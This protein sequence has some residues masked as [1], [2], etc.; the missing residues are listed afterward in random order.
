MKVFIDMDS[1]LN[2]FLKG[3]LNYYNYYFDTDIYKT[4][5]DLYQ[6]E[7]SKCID[8][9]DEYTAEKRREIIFR[10]SNFWLDLPPFPYVKDVVGFIYQHCDV[11]ILTQPYLK[12][13][14]CFTEKLLWVQKYLP[15]FPLDRVI[16]SAF[17]DVF[18]S[19][20]LLIDDKP[21]H[22]QS[23]RGKTMAFDYPFNRGVSVDY[24]AYNWLGVKSNIEKHIL[25]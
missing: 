10:A 19:D 17:K 16:F 8:D 22:L 7:I 13:K 14:D 24:R 5:E 15:F 11:Y 6:Y 20:S 18:I 12:Y 2:N 1:T 4:R 3:Y 25:Q 9:I 21:S 23:F